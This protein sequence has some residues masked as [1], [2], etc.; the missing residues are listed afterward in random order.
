MNATPY[1][2]AV[3]QGADENAVFDGLTH[4]TLLTSAA[5]HQK[6]RDFITAHEDGTQPP[7]GGGTPSGLGVTA[8]TANSVSLS[9]TG[10][11]GVAGYNVYRASS[12]TGPWTKVNGTVVAG[13][14]YTASGLGA[15]TTYHFMVRGQKGDG[16]ETGDS[17]TVSQTTASGTPYSESVNATVY[18]H[19]TAG[20]VTYSGYITLGQRYGYVAVVTLY[21]CGN[22]WTDKP[23]CAPL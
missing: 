14:A 8:F 3:L 1:A 21:R 9:W 22:T 2:T 20:R 15:G 7:D 4:Y 12:A 18:A 11:S 6:I 16:T 17:N 5:V 13:N 10:V 23:S 19:Y